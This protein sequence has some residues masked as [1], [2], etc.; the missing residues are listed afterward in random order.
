MFDN[1]LFDFDGTLVDSEP[2]ILSTWR[3]T[4]ST[5]GLPLRTEA[6][7]R[8]LIGPP[9]VDVVA[10]LTDDPTLQRAIATTYFARYDTVGVHE[11]AMYDGVAAML[12]ELRSRGCRLAIATSKTEFIAVQMLEQFDLLPYFDGVAGALRDGSR[13][14]KHQVVNYAMSQLPPGRAIHVGDRSHDVDGARANDLDCI[15]VLW[16]YGSAE[17]LIE[18]GAKEL[19]ATPND[20]VDIVA[21]LAPR[22]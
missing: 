16:G 22:G 15:G 5:L 18:A 12:A 1:V 4:F 21:G 9:L 19:A 17:E 8:Q 10:I 20:V 2:G 7:L 11:A 6:E 13:Q 14:H 3:H